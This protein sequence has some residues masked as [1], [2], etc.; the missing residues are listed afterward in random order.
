MKESRGPSGYKL[1][2]GERWP[3]RGEGTK[4]L[5]P[6]LVAM[7]EALEQLSVLVGQRV[8]WLG[9]GCN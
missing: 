5:P 9:R 3:G 8:R 4:P 1:Y 2:D 6:L 7:V